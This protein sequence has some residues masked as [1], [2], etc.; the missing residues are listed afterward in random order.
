MALPSFTV[1]QRAVIPLWDPE[2]GFRTSRVMSQRNVCVLFGLLAE[3]AVALRYVNARC[4]CVL[5]SCYEHV[6]GHRQIST[7][8]APLHYGKV[9][10]QLLA[11][12]DFTSCTHWIVTCGRGEEENIFVP[13]GNRTPSVQLSY[14]SLWQGRNPLKCTVNK[15]IVKVKG[16][17][18]PVPKHHTTNSNRY[19][20]SGGQSYTYS[21]D[22]RW[23]R[24]VSFMF[25]LLHPFSQRQSHRCPFS[26]RPAGYRRQF[27]NMTWHREVSPCACQQWNINRQLTAV[28]NGANYFMSL[29]GRTVATEYGKLACSR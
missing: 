14:P 13:A 22:T 12:A 11:L 3:A 29:R 24:V 7:H 18:S 9:D 20:E 25:R 19:R 6:Q 5:A 21:S 28:S 10:K 23:M 16:E 4:S 26:R 27:G 17:V 1:Q 8:Y 15:W 2:G